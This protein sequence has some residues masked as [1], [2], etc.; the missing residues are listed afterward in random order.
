MLICGDQIKNVQFIVKGI[1]HTVILL[2]MKSDFVLSHPGLFLDCGVEGQ[3]YRNS[4]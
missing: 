3:I 4:K 1:N 2:S